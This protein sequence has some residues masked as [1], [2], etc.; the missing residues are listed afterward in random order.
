MSAMQSFPGGSQGDSL[1]GTLLTDRQLTHEI[2]TAA[3]SLQVL[4]RISLDPGAWWYRS[5]VTQNGIELSEG[6]WAPVVKDLSQ[7]MAEFAITDGMRTAFAREALV[8]H[9]SRVAELERQLGAGKVGAAKP[10]PKIVPIATVLI[11]VVAAGIFGSYWH[12]QGRKP[13]PAPVPA[14]DAE[15]AKVTVPDEPE[16]ESASPTEVTREEEETEP[17]PT[18]VPSISV[19][20][21]SPTRPIEPS[22]TAP[23]AEERTTVEEAP[24]GEREKRRPDRGLFHNVSPARYGLAFL[25]V[26]NPVYEDPAY[27]YADVPEAFQGLTCLRVANSQE[28]EDAAVSFTLSRRARVMVA[29]DRRIKKRPGW[30]RSFQDTGEELRVRELGEGRE[31]AYRIYAEELGPGRVELGESSGA[32]RINK[33]LR[34]ALNRERNLYVVC[35]R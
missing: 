15:V 9:L 19:G 24:R 5:S 30:L 2:P 22:V 16:P 31:L 10:L 26:G 32:T 29:H 11:L 12:F 35:A 21:G 6:P 27:V 3:G 8:V 34:E 17:S 20:L 28:S 1:I 25:A 14:E 7:E 33:R 18:P 13:A 23:R 4:T